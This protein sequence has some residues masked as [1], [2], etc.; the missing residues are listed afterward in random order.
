MDI[1]N[2]A[3]LIDS[4]ALILQAL[5]WPLIIIFILIYFGAPLK[6]FLNDVGEL[7]LDFL[8]LRRI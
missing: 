1:G 6:K 8:V 7:N 4:I 2:V 3:K 5:C